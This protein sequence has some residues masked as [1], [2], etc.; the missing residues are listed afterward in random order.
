MRRKHC[1]DAC[2]MNALKIVTRG[3]AKE[4]QAAAA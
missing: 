3:E 4:D 1:N 2:P